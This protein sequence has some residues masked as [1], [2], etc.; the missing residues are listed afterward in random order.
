MAEYMDREDFINLC[1]LLDAYGR[2]K[3]GDEWW[4]GNARPWLGEEDGGE[5][6]RLL[7]ASD[8]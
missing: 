7:E 4:P 8:R 2:A 1:E 3:F 5:L 6:E